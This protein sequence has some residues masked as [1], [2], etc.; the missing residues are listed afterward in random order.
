MTIAVIYWYTMI[1]TI[2]IAMILKLKWKPCSFYR[3]HVKKSAL[4]PNDFI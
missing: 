3:D 1:I 2:T 4:L